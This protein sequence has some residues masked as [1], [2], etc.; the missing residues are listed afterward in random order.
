MR[1]SKMLM[2]FWI[3]AAVLLGSCDRSPE[4]KLAKHV[5][6]GDEYAKEEK[7][8]EA[9]I[10]YKNAVKAVPMDPAAH[11]KLAKASIEAKDLRTAFAELQ[12][13]V[14]LDPNNFEA[15]GKLG[16][17]YVMAG[18]TDEAAQIADNLIKSR[19]N[20]PQGYILQSGLAVRAGKVDSISR[21]VPRR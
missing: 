5:K 3:L 16:E 15:L 2:A 18:K 12:K 10:E 9:V 13:T 6:R 11:W 20:D 4:A 8:K 19:P 14:E 17:I 21:D 7:F 1:R